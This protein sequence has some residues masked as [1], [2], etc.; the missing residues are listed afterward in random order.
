MKFSARVAVLLAS[1]LY[2]GVTTNGAAPFRWMTQRKP[3][4]MR[5]DEGVARA[6]S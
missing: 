6:Y 2:S 5:D 4:V 3:D 1:A